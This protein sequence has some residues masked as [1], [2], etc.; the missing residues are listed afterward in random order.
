MTEETGEPVSDGPDGPD[1]AGGPGGGREASAGA[2]GAGERA[3]ADEG[4]PAGVG[5]PAGEGASAGEVLGE[6]AGLRRRARSDRHAYWFPLV[7]F[8]V[9]SCAAT[10]FYRSAFL[11][12]G[13][14]ARSSGVTEVTLSPGLGAPLTGQAPFGGTFFLGYYWLVALGG[15]DL[16]RA[17]WDRGPARAA[18]VA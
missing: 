13:G 15:G 17:L 5:A 10:P 1:E 6:L 7:L 9:L 12:V 18:G 16:A 2:R 3:S 8:G 11:L 4:V 14:A